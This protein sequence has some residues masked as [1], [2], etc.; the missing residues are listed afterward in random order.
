M[1]KLAD[2]KTSTE[3]RP[4]IISCKAYLFGIWEILHTMRVEYRELPN[5]KE[6]LKYFRKWLRPWCRYLCHYKLIKEY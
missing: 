2:T 1:G 4:L 5:D 3:S 6:W